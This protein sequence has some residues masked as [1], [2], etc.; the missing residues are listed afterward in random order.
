LNFPDVILLTIFSISGFTLKVADFSGEW[1]DRNASILFAFISGFLLGLLIT[2]SAFSSAII[3]GMIIGVGASGKINKP[4]LVLGIVVVVITALIF[5][6][7]TPSFWHLLII[8]FFAFFDEVEHNRF[9]G[10]SGFLAKFFSIRGS[11][12]MVVILL[13]AIGS[14]PILYAGGFLVFDLTYDLTTFLIKKLR[15]VPRLEKIGR[16]A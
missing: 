2:E 10:R 7:S 11:L 13:A 14:L 5:G 16:Q 9:T 1:R 3:L 8:A 6:F 4:N 15:I 12:K